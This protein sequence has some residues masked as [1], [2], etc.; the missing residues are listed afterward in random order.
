MTISE[1]ISE[2]IC[3]TISE[4]KNLDDVSYVWYSYVDAHLSSA[5]QLVTVRD[6]NVAV[7][8]KQATEK[9]ATKKNEKHMHGD[10]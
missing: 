4:D 10:Y 6:R 3:L 5:F 7:P 9:Q 8:W 2:A 1:S